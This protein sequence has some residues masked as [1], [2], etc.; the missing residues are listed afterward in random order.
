MAPISIRIISLGLLRPISLFI[1]NLVIPAFYLENIFFKTNRNRHK[2]YL[3]LIINEQ[4]RRKQR[5]IKRKI[6]YAPGGGELNPRP[7]Q[8]D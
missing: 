1:N 2:P 7:P 4:S 5:G 6:L 8:A 3:S